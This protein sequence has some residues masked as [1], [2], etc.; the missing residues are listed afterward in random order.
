METKAQLFAALSKAQSEIVGAK[1]DSVNPFFKS[2]YAD[3]AACWDACR[4]PLANHKLSVIQLPEGGSEGYLKLRTILGHES[5]ESIES[6]FAMPVEPTPQGYGSALTYMRRYA[7]A[8]V[9]G[10]AQ[11]DDD[12]EGAM[13]RNVEVKYIT[14][15]QVDD[16]EAIIDEVGADKKLFLKWVRADSMEH[17]PASKYTQCIKRLEEKRN[18]AD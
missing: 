11:V 6:V 9:V 13:P 7:L 14:S 10:L 8:A 16:L 12:A 5:G 18:A 4:E 17:I 2:K 15:K 1:K 3:L